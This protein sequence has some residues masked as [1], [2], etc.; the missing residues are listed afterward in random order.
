MLPSG[1]HRSSVSLR[2]SP[3]VDSP[4]PLIRLLSCSLLW[5]LLPY[6]WSLMQG[7]HPPY[8]LPLRLLPLSRYRLLPRLLSKSLSALHRWS[9][10]LRSSPAMDLPLPW[11][12]PLM[13]SPVKCPLLY[14]WSLMQGSH[15]PYSLPLMSLPLSRYRLLRRLR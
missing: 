10:S 1:R 5:C 4:L 3:A 14:S 13:Y 11:L 15:P 12:L 9:V 2:S 7:S 6:S 8:S